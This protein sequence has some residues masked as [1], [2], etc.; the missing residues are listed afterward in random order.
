[1]S[2]DF[3]QAF[4]DELE[5]TMMLIEKRGTKALVV[6]VLSSVDEAKAAGA[7]GAGMLARAVSEGTTRR[8]AEVFIHALRREAD[9]MEK[10]IGGLRTKDRPS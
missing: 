1:M 10:M 9:R 8:D 5:A 2:M 6:G 4:R 3:E 7:D